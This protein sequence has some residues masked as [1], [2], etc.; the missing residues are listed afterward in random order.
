VTL[1]REGIKIEIQDTNI[2]L[3]NDYSIGEL[4]IKGGK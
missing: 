3:G 4:Q 1:L 2:A